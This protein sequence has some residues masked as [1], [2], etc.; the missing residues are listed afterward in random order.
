MLWPLD[1]AIVF[2]E[3]RLVKRYLQTITPPLVGKLL[4]NLDN[5]STADPFSDLY[6]QL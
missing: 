6:I 4:V 2:R 5:Q 3:R 1:C